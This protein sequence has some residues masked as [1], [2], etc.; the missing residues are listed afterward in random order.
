MVWIIVA[1]LSISGWGEFDS[2]LPN[3]L[4]RYVYSYEQQCKVALPSYQAKTKPEIHL[5]CISKSIAH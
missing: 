1:H 4:L 5:A 2:L 3:E